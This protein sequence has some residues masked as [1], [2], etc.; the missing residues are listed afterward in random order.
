M[1][2][3]LLAIGEST[4]RV[5]VATLPEWLA[6]PFAAQMRE[7]FR[8][9]QAEAFALG[10]FARWLGVTTVEISGT[11]RL[12]AG[13]RLRGRDLLRLPRP[14]SASPGSPPGPRH[15]TPEF[16]FMD[17]LLQ[18]ARY[19]ARGL[20]KSPGFAAVAAVTLMLGIGVNST[21][22]SIVNTIL[23]SPLAVEEPDRV[24]AIYGTK[25]NAPVAHDS[26]S[27]LDYLDIREQTGTLS[28]VV[29]Y[30]N[31]FANLVMDGRSEIVIGEIVSDNFFDVLGV[32]PAIGRGF[33]AEEFVAEGAS[34]VAVISDHMWRNRFDADPAI[35]GA[36]VRLNGTSYT[37]V[38]V[39]GRQFGGMFPGVTAQ[40]WLPLTM[41]EEV[42][43]LGNVDT[44]PS[45]SMRPP[46][47]S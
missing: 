1:S 40:L 22:F 41:I 8:E 35:L 10:G 34:P 47:A 33:T 14:T 11:L 27:Y 7:T 19:A 23:L 43:P 2:R 29:A 12:A 25:T 26:N 30:T 24:V 37:V 36:Q 38:G 28:G 20:R 3:A 39:A 6:A 31:F 45:E 32:Q 18:D 9:R 44:S 21:I 4:Y 13:S 15:K 5:A 16:R 17:T 46:Q 42:Q